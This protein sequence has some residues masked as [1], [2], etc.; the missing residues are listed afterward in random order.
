MPTRRAVLTAAL[1]L[2]AL[3]RAASAGARSV[4]APGGIALGGT[5]PV[6]YFSDGAPVAGSPAE[7]L[8]WRGVVW[9]F[10]SAHNRLVFEMS[11]LAYAPRF[12]GYCALALTQGQLVATVPEAWTIHDGRLYLN[13]SL[14]V[15]TRW[16]SDV[17]RHVAEAE[18]FWPSA[19][20]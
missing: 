6:A 5:D 4:F 7:A 15:R 14:P 17:P 13:A 12:G 1:L 20:G 19:L 3:T 10:A 8:R 9:F 2:P 16:R 11:P 18:A